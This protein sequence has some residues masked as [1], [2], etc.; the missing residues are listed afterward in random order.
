MPKKLKAW[1]SGLNEVPA[2]SSS[3]SGRFEARISDDHTA[4]DYTLS[5]QGMEGK[6][7]MAHIH[8]GQH[9]ANGGISY[10]FCGDPASAVPPPPTVS[11]PICDPTSGTLQ[12]TIRAADIL[13]P[14]GQGIAPGEFDEFIHLLKRG[15]TYVNIYSDKHA[16]GEIRGQIMHHKR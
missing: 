9:F 14:N 15:M 13:G 16:P 5:Y 2:L 8:I 7:F 6:V 10:W 12:G 1:A 3:G 11:V 4:I